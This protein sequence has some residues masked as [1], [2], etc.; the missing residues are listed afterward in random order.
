MPYTIPKEF[1]I[2]KLMEL[3]D[4]FVA[5]ENFNYLKDRKLKPSDLEKLPLLV[6]TKGA[7][8]RIR[9]DEYCTENKITIHPEM[10]F[11]SNTLIKEFTEAGFGIGMLTYEHVKKELDDGTLFKLNIEIP[12]KEKN[13]AMINNPENRSLITKNFINYIKDNTSN[14]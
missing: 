5:N 2:Y 10:E 6:L 1:K 8:T 9:L 12:L 3:H 14:S 4:C 11:G 7:T 13:L